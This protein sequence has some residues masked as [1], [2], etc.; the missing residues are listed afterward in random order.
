[1]RRKSTSSE[2][3]DLAY[4]ERLGSIETQGFK[5]YGKGSYGNM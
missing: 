1:M 3:P 4:F 2:A 5:N